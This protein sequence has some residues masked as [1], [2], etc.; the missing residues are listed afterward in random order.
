MTAMRT[1][2]AGR[3]AIAQREGNKL[4]AY[5][6]S[7]G[8]WTIGVGHTTVAG[9][10]AV[11][12]G[13]KITAGES[14]DILTRDLAGVEADINRMVK[15]PLSQSQFDA[16]VSLV[17]NIGG[18]AFGKST[19]LKKLNARDYGGAAEQFLVWNKGTISGKRVAIQG[20]TTRRK[21]ERVQ[22]LAEDAP[23]SPAPA[24]A[25]PK[26]KTDTTT[27]RVVQERLKELG[28]TE[29]GNPDGKMGK[30]TKTAILAFRNENDIPVSDVIDDQLLQALD[31][32]S[33]RN[34]PR[35]D[36]EP[37]TV[38]EAVPEVQSNF[39]TKVGAGGLAGTLG[40]GSLGDLAS[41][42]DSVRGWINP[43]KE[44]FADIPGWAW[45]GCAALVLVAIAL[46]ARRGEMKGI[47]AF[48]AGERR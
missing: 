47:A 40:V 3:K 29:V 48:Q 22:F 38:R 8:V 13:L 30:L 4:T 28:Y 39:L 31:D 41:K 24:I 10:P 7:V 6:D 45:L 25:T 42:A 20:L 36:A 35:N 12:K 26:S 17:F 21:A 19:L 32:A 23:A 16:L 43:W 14:D 15:A 33:P 2:A 5:L 37:A 9:P 34:L 27:I 1:S 18:G 11:S 46:I 44:M